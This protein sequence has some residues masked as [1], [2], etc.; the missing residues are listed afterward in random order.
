MRIP[1][2]TS[3]SARWSRWLGGFAFPVSILPIFLHRADAIESELFILI[4]TAGLCSAALAVL[5]G[6]FAMVRLWFT[7]DR[8]WSRALWGVAFGL[9]C[10]AYPAVAFVLG[11]RSPATPDIATRTNI[12]LPVTLIQVDGTPATPAD[13]PVL[14]AAFPNISPRNYAVS[15][16]ELFDMALLVVREAGW[17]AVQTR[18]PSL[19]TTTGT[20]EAVGKT[21]TG[22]DFEV[23]VR[24]GR[25]GDVSV[26]DARAASEFFWTDFGA[27]GSR[28]QEFL[29]ALDDAITN[30]ARENVLP[31]PI[32]RPDLET[33]GQASE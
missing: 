33:D 25:E 21:L 30:Y 6:V 28:L 29:V 27:N 15:P 18:A 23:S 26:L 14:V 32:P 24:T 2:R 16:N 19:E 12:E 1:I 17:D 3:R 5:S 11:A 10:L 13:D 22:W 20:I 4:V 7:G 9:T 31:F 8:G